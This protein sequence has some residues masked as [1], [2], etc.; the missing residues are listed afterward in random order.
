M[1][2]TG[3]AL[4]LYTTRSFYSAFSRKRFMFVSRLIA[5]QQQQENV[6]WLKWSL[7]KKVLVKLVSTVSVVCS[8]DVFFLA[9]SGYTSVHVQII[10]NFPT[11]PQSASMNWY[12]LYIL[13]SFNAKNIRKYFVRS[14]RGV[15]FSK[16][17]G[18]TPNQ[19]GCSPTTFRI[20]TDP[21]TIFNSNPVA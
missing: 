12:R 1:S 20:I 19:G 4:L 11:Q 7:T 8:T 17:T 13:C 9:I 10:V 18:I 6:Q 14:F 3:K 15:N 2:H 16:F 5:D 21:F